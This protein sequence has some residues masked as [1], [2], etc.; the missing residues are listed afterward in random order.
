MR[1]ITAFLT[2]AF[3]TFACTQQNAEKKAGFDGDYKLWNE[4]Q[5]K[6]V[7]SYNLFRKA[8]TGYRQ[9]NNLKKKDVLTIIDFSKPSSENRFF[10][11]DLKNKKLLFNCLVAHGKNSG[12]LYAASFSNE[13]NSLK[14]SLGFFITAETYYGANGY[15]L[16][17]DG[18]EKGI[19]DKAREREI[20]I[21][22]ADYVCQS[23]VTRYGRIGRS[24]GCPA[25][26]EELAEKIINTISNGSCL[27]IYADDKFY[28]EHS[29]L[30]P[31][32]VANN[33]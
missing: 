5:L 4:C 29:Q 16:K 26:P 24:W 9:I 12:D 20:V 15:S 11:V 31:G 3:L 22:G 19:N 18:I 10:V 33:K 30:I 25:L 2:F 28:M 13:Q 17:L 6:D 7:M 8:L 23:F 27:F 1:I 21:H 32:L 14:S